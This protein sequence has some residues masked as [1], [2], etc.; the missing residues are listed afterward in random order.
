MDK[1]K[2]PTRVWVDGCFDMMHWGHANLLRK[3]KQLGDILVVGVHSDAEVAHHKGPPVMDEACR[4]EAVKVCK[5]V[6]EVVEDAPYVTTLHT[7]DKHGCDFCVHGDD[8]TT[9]AQGNDSYREVKQ[10]GRF[11]EVSRTFGVSTTDM[12]GR[13]LLCTHSH[14]TEPVGHGDMRI[15]DQLPQNLSFE[16][17]SVSDRV[18]SIVSHVP[19]I[20]GDVPPVFAAELSAILGLFSGGSE[21]DDMLVAFR[22]YLLDVCHQFTIGLH[23][24]SPTARVVYMFGTWDLFHA[25][26]ARALQAARQLGDYVIVGVASDQTVVEY[27]GRVY[28]IM[29]QCERVLGLLSCRHVDGMIVNAPLVLTQSFLDEHNIAVVAVGEGEEQE[30]YYQQAYRVPLAQG[31]VRTVQSGSDMTTSVILNQ[32][33][34]NRLKFEE[35]NARKAKKTQVEV[36]LENDL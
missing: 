17:G 19:S 1:D 22:A 3:A 2:Q 29:N 12:V 33:V 5:W 20:K 10:A 14:I 25:G 36:R 11:R 28:P 13:L 24:W 23:P 6:D 21:H 27:K 9:D 32:I 35:R 4:Y 7:L 26:H 30:D 18:S 31:M 34:N 8:I 16:T 15:A